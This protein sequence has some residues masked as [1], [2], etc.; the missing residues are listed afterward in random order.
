MLELRTITFWDTNFC[1]VETD[2]WIRPLHGCTN[3]RW[4]GYDHKTALLDETSITSNDSIPYRQIEAKRGR[5]EHMEQQQ[6]A[7]FITMSTTMKT[8]P[9]GR[10]ADACT[11]DPSLALAG[12]R[13]TSEVVQIAEA[14]TESA[15]SQSRILGQ[16]TGRVAV[17]D[18]DTERQHLLPN[19]QHILRN[20]ECPDVALFDDISGE[21]GERL[22]PVNNATSWGSDT[23]TDVEDFN[24][25][26]QCVYRENM[27]DSDYPP[28]SDLLCLYLSPAFSEEDA[29]N[30][31]VYGIESY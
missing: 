7:K 12:S 6:V 20:Y 1:L 19:T 15:S 28:G 8:P 4:V 10:K 18:R 16:G 23:C 31:P 3:A 26:N 25:E 21:F 27:Y 2:I 5:H 14:R 29:G 17:L 22:L 9:E 24:K 30:T 13:H 11:A